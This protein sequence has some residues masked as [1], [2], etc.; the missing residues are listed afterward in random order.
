MKNVFSYY[1]QQNEIILKV[2][3]LPLTL[4]VNLS[5]MLFKVII[6]QTIN[7]KH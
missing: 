6:N 3:L 4:V 7:L 2:L 5:L 1:H